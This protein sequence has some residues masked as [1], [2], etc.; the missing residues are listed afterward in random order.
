M[1]H[2][3][4]WNGTDSRTK[5]IRV[6]S[7]V[8]VVQP[9]ER[10]DRVT[11]PGRRG[12][13][14]LTEGADIY[15]GYIQSVDITVE[16][17]ANIPAV[18]NWLKGAGVIT[19]DTQPTFAQNAR[20]IGSGTFERHS[21]NLDLW[22]ATVQFYCEPVKSSTTEQAITV[23][24]SGTSVNNTGDMTAYPLIEITGSGAVTVAAGGN[25]LVI[26]DCTS[27]WVIDSE[28]EWILSGNTP[29]EQVCSGAFPVLLKGANAVTFTGSVTKLVITPRFRYL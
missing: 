21:R 8:P 28:N 1:R 27:G 20:V 16:G 19:F 10:I 17:K 6:P 29:Q 25:T 3:F 18:Q 24:T 13:V 14:T 2:Y 22:H 15:S 11:I 9:E 23:T 26:P 7:A 5:H 12:E 4:L